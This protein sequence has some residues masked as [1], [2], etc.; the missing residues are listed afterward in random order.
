VKSER[1]GYGLRIY[2]DAL[3][4]DY[5]RTQLKGFAYKIIYYETPERIP[6]EHQKSDLCGVCRKELLPQLTNHI[7]ILNC[8][9]L[10]HWQCLKREP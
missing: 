10:F 9:H 3:I 1:R 8:G 2:W 5:K 4:K 6:E 7:T